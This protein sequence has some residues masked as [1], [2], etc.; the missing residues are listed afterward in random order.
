MK[1]IKSKVI[2]NIYNSIASTSKFKYDIKKKK[3]LNKVINNKEE[4]LIYNV[5]KNKKKFTTLNEFALWYTLN[6]HKIY[7]TPKIS[8][9]NK[10]RKE[11]DILLY[12]NPFVSVDIHIIAEINDLVYLKV[13]SDKIELH[14]YHMKNEVP[15]I[16]DII[17]IC[18]FMRHIIGSTRKILLRILHG[19]S[20]KQLELFDNKLSPINTNSGSSLKGSFINIWRKEEL[21]KVLIHELIHYLY[22]DDEPYNSGYDTLSNNIKKK[23]NM[24]SRIIPNEAY[25]EALATIIHTVY[26]SYKLGNKDL[27]TK[28]IKTEITYS[29]FQVSKI[30]NSFNI[31][32]ANPKYFNKIN[33]TTS[34]FSYYVIKSALLYSLNDFLLFVEKSIK[35]NKRHN[36]FKNLIIECVE[37]NDYLKNIQYFIN[38]V[39]S[40]EDDFIRK[41]MRMTCL[42][43]R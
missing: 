40:I 14:I 30:F 33:Q 9:N 16:D 18:H 13:I 34:I 6:Q 35:F 11:L 39:D 43:L 21:R 20:K 24:N 38:K 1:P 28:L 42:E 32:V 25:T 3:L 37:N 19:Y 12:D 15:P 22:I 7:D 26:I 17:H 36:E 2:D 23:Y 27:F 31:K 4:C 10:Y 29:L 5:Y 41:T 8:T